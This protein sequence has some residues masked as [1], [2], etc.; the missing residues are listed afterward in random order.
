MRVAIAPFLRSCPKVITLGVRP[1]LGDYDP[2]E[3]R[4]LASCNRVFFPT[5][6][7]APIFNAAGKETFP[8]GFTYRVRKSRLAAEVLFQFHACPHPRTLVYFGRRKAS[9]PDDFRFPCRAMGPANSSPPRLIGSPEELETVAALWNPL[10]IQEDSEYRERFRVVFVNF[11]CIAIHKIHKI[12]KLSAPGRG[13]EAVEPVGAARIGEEFI[14]SHVARFVRS[15]YLNDI[16]VEIGLERKAG[17]QMLALTRPPL[18][19]RSPR[20]VVNRHEYIAGLIEAE[21]L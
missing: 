21:T 8:S 2:R 5:P 15:A 20:G 7:F 11:E 13:P 4:L 1:A 12:H 6:R 9:I 10:I 17:W 18:A 16:A 14:G 19:W 3:I